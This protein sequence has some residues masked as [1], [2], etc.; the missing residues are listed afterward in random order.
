MEFPLSDELIGQIIFAME[1][2]HH[3][4]HINRQTGEL[5]R[6][7]EPAPAEAGFREE[8]VLPPEYVP[9]P[10]WRPIHGFHLM[11]KF[12]AKLRNPVLREQLKEALGSG[13]GVFRKFKDILKG[14]REIEHLWF[15]FKEREMRQV[16]WAWYNEQRE[17]AGLEKIS[18]EPQVEAEEAEELLGSDFSIVEGGK[19]HLEAALKL[20]R[21]AV[22]ALYPEVEPGRLEVFYEQRLEQLGSPLGDRSFLL[23]AE[24]AERDFAGF[25]WALE[26]SDPLTETLHLKVVQL[27]VVKHYRGMGLGSLLLKRL[28]REARDRGYHRVVVELSGANLQLTSFLQE[29]GFG[30]RSQTLQLDPSRWEG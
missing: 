1:D 29:L 19:E 9:I 30:P 4:Y 28:V 12:V 24:T 14:S 6:A 2:Q 18:H 23:V 17:L 26:E 7:E 3:C 21:G 5:H 25:V 11:E 16:V 10:E 13:R 20:D 15:T 22:T 8:R 27:A